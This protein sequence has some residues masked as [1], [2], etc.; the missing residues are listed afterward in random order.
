MESVIIG[1]GS[2]L[3]ERLQILQQAGTFLE[4]LSSGSIKKA[5]I[6]ES[7]PI[8]PSKFPFLNTV[9]KIET[10]KSPAKLL[11]SLKEFEQDMGREKNPERWGPRILDLDIIAFGDLVIQK[12]NLIIPHSEY[13]RR[14]FVLLPLQEIEAEWMDPSTQTSISDMVTEA[15]N[16]QIHKTDHTW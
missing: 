15:P 10:E 3:G 7:E 1:V 11:R 5:S 12:E 6:W 8:G 4:A 9:A 13:R 14:L 2:N 16:M